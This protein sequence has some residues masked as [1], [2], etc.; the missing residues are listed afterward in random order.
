MLKHFNCVTFALLWA[1]VGA[2]G[3]N[4]DDTTGTEGNLAIGN[5]GTASAGRGGAGASGSASTAVTGGRGAT[6]GSASTAG[7]EGLGGAAGAA[8]LGGGGSGGMPAGSASLTGTLGAL[9]ALQPTVSSLVIS[10]SGETLIYMS[11][12]PITCELLTMSR[13]LGSVATG[14]Q[15]VEI[16]VPS[17]R[18][19]GTVPVEDGG[20]EV[21]YAP[22]G[23]SSAYEETAASGS[24][25]F[26]TS[27][28]NGVVEGSVM[29]TYAN[30]TGDVS[31]TF[32][33][34]FCAGGQGY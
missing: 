2:C 16:V 6:A 22:G 15:V 7:R 3:S 17:N 30:P 12:A 28:P 5:A 19:S 24:V 27:M 4:D 20:A 10:N 13:W 25:T 9:G 14:S 23:M 8:T 11:S 32:H 33:A 31:G 1:V 34:E 21:N 29:A 18:A 26:T